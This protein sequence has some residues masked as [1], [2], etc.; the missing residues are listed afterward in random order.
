MS[1]FAKIE[2][3]IVVEVLVAEQDFIDSIEGEWVQ[4]SYNTHGGYHYKE[5][6]FLSDD[7]TKAFRKNYA[8]V[9]FSYDR[10]KDAFIPPQPFPSW[11][12]EE[13]SCT[14]H[15]PIDPPSTGV[16]NWDEELYQSD[17]TQGWIPFEVST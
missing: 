3:N 12:F 9:G 4:T 17:N 15:A 8:N 10:D 11:L 6:G 7:Q 13:F 16:Y 14:W 5:D 1:H 2:N